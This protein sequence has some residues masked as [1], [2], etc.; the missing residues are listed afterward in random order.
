MRALLLLLPLAISNVW[1]G[2]SSGWGYIEKLG[3]RANSDLLTITFSKPVANPNGCGNGSLGTSKLYIVE[4]DQTKNN[5]FIS[6]LTAAYM[7]KKE[8]AFWVPDE[9]TKNKY[10]GLTRPT[11]FDIQVRD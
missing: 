8:V 7:A 3:M 2:Q 6:T 4:L 11:V 10:W 5:Y 1:A 9:C